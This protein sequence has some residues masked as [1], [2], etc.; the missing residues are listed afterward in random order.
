MMQEHYN[1]QYY[2]YITA[3]HAYLKRRDPHY[4]YHKHFG[5]A[6][7]LFI[8]GMSVEKGPEYGI[9][10][11]RPDENIIADLHEILIG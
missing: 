1:L 4:E 8:R 9:F 11:K 7:Y 3:L 6:F 2:L 10:Y 5:G